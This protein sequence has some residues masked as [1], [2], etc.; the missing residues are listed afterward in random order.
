M[1]NETHAADIIGA[2]LIDSNGDKVGKIGQLY[3]DD[4]TGRPEWVSV[5]TGLFGTKESFVPLA[6]G[7]FSDGEVRVPYS[8][9]QIKD[10][11]KVDADGHLDASEED[12]L[13]SHYGVSSSIA[14]ERDSRSGGT[15]GDIDNDTLTRAETDAAGMPADRTGRTE[16]DVDSGITG[17]GMGAGMQTSGIGAAGERSAGHDTSGP[18]TDDAMTRSEERVHAGTENVQTGQARLRKWIETENVQM[19]VPVKR[20]RAVLEREPITDANAGA[21]MS[22][23]ALSEEEHEVTLSEE[24][25]V[26]EKETVPVE[27]VRLGKETEV[28]TE[29]VSED[30]SKERIEAEGDIVDLRS[31]E[32]RS[33][34]R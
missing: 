23:P 22:G 2:Q 28:D 20:E 17:S 24:R 32:D 19:E 6:D 27:R 31:A 11:P 14:A 21:A 12:A 15:T 5:N 3:L 18:D 1:I 33:S 25:P 10:A 30:V 13:Y 7:T 9:D 29:T 34:T 4:Q 26:V 16:L 8:K